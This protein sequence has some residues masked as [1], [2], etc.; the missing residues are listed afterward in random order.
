[1]SAPTVEETTSRYAKLLGREIADIGYY[2][3]F[4]SLRLAVLR[5]KLSILREGQPDRAE[6]DAGIP[7]LANVL[8]RYAGIEA[9]ID[10]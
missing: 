4:A 1:M 10:R 7:R 6:P 3:V 2:M 9:R 8:A 5:I